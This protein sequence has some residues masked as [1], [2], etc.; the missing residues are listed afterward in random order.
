MIVV[1][2]TSPLTNLAAIGKFHLLRDL[3]GYIHIPVAVWNE[4]NAFGRAWPGRDEVL[5]A[6]WVTRRSIQNVPLATALQRDLDT[7]EA[8]TI[9]LALEMKADLV[10]M[11]EREGRHI[12]QRLGLNVVGVVGILIA[13]KAHSLVD[14]IQ[15]LLDDLRHKAGFYLND[16][17]YRKALEIAGEIPSSE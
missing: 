10:L 2:N 1:S 11:D 17:V 7:G 14:T 12:A 15:P 8:E 9:A 3:Y 6:E 4:L 16:A 13:A 5:A